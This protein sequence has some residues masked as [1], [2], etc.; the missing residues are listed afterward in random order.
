MVLSD[1]LSDIISDVLTPKQGHLAC[2]TKPFKLEEDKHPVPERR[3]N[4]TLHLN[5]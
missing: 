1:G 3:K 5:R 2:V 4:K